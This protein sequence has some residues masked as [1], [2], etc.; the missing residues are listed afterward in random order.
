MNHDSKSN[1]LELVKDFSKYSTSTCKSER[2]LYNYLEAFLAVPKQGV[3][4]PRL[5]LNTSPEI[6][7]VERSIF[8]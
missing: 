3:I 4:V 7:P 1:E 5:A 8:R 2:H 6:S